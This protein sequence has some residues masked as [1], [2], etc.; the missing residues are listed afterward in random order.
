MKIERILVPVDF[1]EH[2]LTALKYAIELARDYESEV[3]IVH[4]VEPLPRGTSRWSD[5]TSL[6]EKHGEKASE[7]LKRFEEEATQLYP[8]CRSELCFGV[9]HEVIGQLVRKL[10]VDLIVISTRGQTPLLDLL[11][12]GTADQLLRRAPCHVLRLLTI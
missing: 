9:V 3:V 6:L 7:E 10:N 4:V 8:K 12:G 5:A 2:S 1:S 11:I